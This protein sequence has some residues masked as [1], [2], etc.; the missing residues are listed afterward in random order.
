MIKPLRVLLVFAALI[1]LAVIWAV[2]QTTRT[3]A[4]VN[5]SYTVNST[6]DFTDGFCKAAHYGMR[7]TINTANSVPPT[8]IILFDF[9][10]AAAILPTS[11][12]P[13]IT[14]PVIIDAVDF[15]TRTVPVQRIPT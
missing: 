9:N 7:E 3:G 15:S 12:L 4:M 1:T 2:V 6:D 10:G 14:D 11:A 5:N 13:E 8:D